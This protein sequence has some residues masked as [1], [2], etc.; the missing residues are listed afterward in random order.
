VEVAVEVAVVVGESSS[1][2]PSSERG[3]GDDELE[4]FE[5]RIGAVVDDVDDHAVVEAVTAVAVDFVVAV[6]VP[7]AWLLPLLLGAV[8]VVVVLL[9]L[10]P[11]ARGAAGTD[12]T[13]CSRPKPYRD[14]CCEAFCMAGVACA[15]TCCRWRPVLVLCGAIW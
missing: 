12:G 5:A 10:V 11:I 15:A 4:F 14:F 1:P 13:T 3:G 6:V 2:P 8:L 7:L 9:L